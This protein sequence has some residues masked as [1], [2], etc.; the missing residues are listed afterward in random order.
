MTKHR[1]HACLPEVPLYT[2]PCN[3]RFG[4]PVSGKQGC[5]LV[6]EI[7]SR[8]EKIGPGISS[9]PE[10]M[11]LASWP[12]PPPLKANIRGPGSQA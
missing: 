2:L 8:Q 9:G 1:A 3:S 11:A 7:Q 4:E 10:L 5:C 12:L 6:C